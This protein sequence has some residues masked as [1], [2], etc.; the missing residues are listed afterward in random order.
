MKAGFKQPPLP[1]A[2]EGRDGVNEIFSD[3]SPEALKVQIELLSAAGLKRRFALVR[4]LS[5]MASALSMRAI[6]RANPN[7]DENQ[8]KIRYARL[9]Y[10]DELANRLAEYMNRNAT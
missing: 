9:H 4:S 1:L 5:E 8:I 7:D 2:G 3:T 10:G 6:R